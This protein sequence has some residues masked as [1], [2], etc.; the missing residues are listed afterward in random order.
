MG[1]N[2]K[3]TISNS[4]GNKQSIQTFASQNP[5]PETVDFDHL[6]A[7]YKVSDQTMFETEE[8]K[9]LLIVK[10]PAHK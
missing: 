5:R 3:C 7:P 2:V 4:K 9:A 6:L 8:F 1:E 10:N